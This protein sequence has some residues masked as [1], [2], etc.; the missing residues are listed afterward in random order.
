MIVKIAP[1]QTLLS[2][3]AAGRVRREQVVVANVDQLAVV[4]AAV[5][6]IYHKRLIDRYLIA[7]DKGDLAPMIVVNKVDLVADD[8]LDDLDADF[9]GY[10]AI[11]I[12]VHF[13]SASAGE[14]MAEF[15]AAL[16]GRATLLSGPSGVGKSSIINVLAETHLAVGEISAL[17][18]K[19]RHTTTGARYLPLDTRSALVDSPGIREFAIWE[20]DVDELPYYFPEFEVAAR[21]CRFQPCSHTHEPG[22]AVKRGVEDGEI[23]EERYISYC[24]LLFDL[25]TQGTEG[26]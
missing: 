3:K 6:P 13:V 17:Y 19:G 16:V 23:D 22:C 25:Q 11:G 8:D 5:Q 20:L 18:A 9:A 10:E 4:V 26:R 7:A 2:R 1:R 21:E 14:G 15:R 12:P 24:N